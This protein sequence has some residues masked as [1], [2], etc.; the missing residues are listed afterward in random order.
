MA[1]AT[2]TSMQLAATSLNFYS[3][4]LTFMDPSVT[5]SQKKATN[6]FKSNMYEDSNCYLVRKHV[7][8][9]AGNLKNY[10]GIV[11]STLQG[12]KVLVELE[13]HLQCQEPFDIKS[14][15]FM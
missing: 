5:A 10:R 4:S 1:A 9:T 6:D 15:C 13:A 2:I 7:V 12:G 3:L 14:P 8:V 11:K